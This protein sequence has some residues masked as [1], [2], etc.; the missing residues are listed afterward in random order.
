[1]SNKWGDHAGAATLGQHF[2]FEKRYSSNGM[3]SCA[4]C[5]NPSQGWQDS[6]A[7]TSSGP[8]PTRF[9]GRH[10]P[11]VINAAYG[12]GAPDSACWHFWD[13]R[14]DSQW[15]QALGPPESDV[16]MGGTR[17][18]IAYLITKHYKTQYTGVF[19]EFPAALWKADG[20]A[21]GHGDIKTG[22]PEWEALGATVQTAINTVYVNFGK[23]ISAYERKIISRES[24]ADRYLRELKA[25][26]PESEIFSSAEKLGLKVF[27]SK[28]R[29]VTCH[30]GA[31]YSDWK[32]YNI[33]E[34]Q[35]APNV[36][37]ADEGRAEGVAK[38]KSGEFNCNSQWSDHPNKASCPINKVTVSAVDLGAFKTPGLRDVSKTAPY[39]HTGR[40]KTLEEVVDHYNDGGG[41]AGT[42]VGTPT[43]RSIV[44]LGL[45]VDEKAGLVAF[46]KALDGAPLPNSIV[47]AP[48]VTP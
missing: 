4:T 32:F 23:A 9:T 8:D 19:G 3:V 30:R 47:E 22:S 1:V 41:Q 45:T 24:K 13:G 20:S 42:F 39:M 37:A 44:K 40:L 12:S 15:S 38:A 10:A 48:P 5:H 14:A 35:T 33:G 25:G 29:C 28:G 18:R 6:R 7:N 2:Y 21:A 43:E 11:T 36:P 17:T 27:V 16:E 46:M 34:S 26:K 31:N